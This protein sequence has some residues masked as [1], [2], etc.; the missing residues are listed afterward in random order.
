MMLRD[1]ADARSLRKQGET[2]A[3]AGY[4]ARRCSYF[5][6]GLPVELFPKSE[7]KIN[8]VSHA[9]RESLLGNRE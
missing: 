2:D 1:N 9:T 6:L 5:E 4:D 8:L 3:F 7:L